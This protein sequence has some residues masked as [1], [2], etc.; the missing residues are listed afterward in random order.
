[1]AGRRGR[2]EL[3]GT[4]KLPEGQTLCRRLGRVFLKVLDGPEAGRESKLL[5]T[6]ITGGRTAV[7]DLVLSAASVSATHFELRLRDEGVLLRDLGSTNGT[8]IRG[9]RVR[10][11]W[12]EPGVTFHAGRCGIKLVAADPIDVPVSTQH[13]FETM[14]GTSEAM[15]EAF[16]MLEQAAPTPMD[17]LLYGE[18]GTGKELAAR[19]L[20]AHS[21]RSKGPF[22]VL[23]CGAL[24]SELAEAAVLGYRKGAFTGAV[25]DTPGCFED[26]KGGTLFIDELGELPL[27]LQPKLLRVL[28]RREVQRVGDTRVRPVD[29]RIVAATHRDIRRMVG[30]ELFRE[31]L[32]FRLAELTVELP[33]LRRRRDDILVLAQNFLDELGA[34]LP[35]PR[36]LAKDALAALVAHPWPGNVRE[37]KKAI[38]RAVY[39]AP[40]HE[41]HAADLALHRGEPTRDA[42]ALD[43][44]L[45]MPLEQAREAFE[46]LF[47]SR[48]LESTGGNITRAAERVGY[49]RHGLRDLLQRRGVYRKT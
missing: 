49:T 40:S 45:S 17:V 24:P 48:L 25:A 27:A 7:N 41:I 19:G 3:E 8:F 13:R 43:E 12:L 16:A 4:L 21:T 26:A 32:Y 11:A 47:L 33:P 28:D 35:E 9:T 20:H 46:A 29:V 15:R 1:M 10:E 39:L 42:D 38:K 14:L 23:D 6:R 34:P 22:V 37:L 18:T 5:A 2:T 30:E 44:V 31:D 36:T